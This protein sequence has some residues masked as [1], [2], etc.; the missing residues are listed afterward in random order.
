M[1]ETYDTANI[2]LLMWGYAISNTYLCLSSLLNQFLK[3]TYF[4]TIIFK[5][6]K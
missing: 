4:R 6:L 3:D 5:D 2:I 1:D